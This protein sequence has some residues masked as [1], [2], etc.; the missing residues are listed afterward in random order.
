MYFLTK[1]EQR[2]NRRVKDHEYMLYPM[3]AG[4]FSLIIRLGGREKEERH[5]NRMYRG[6]P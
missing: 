2:L 1:T 3:E 6:S 4:L 5:G